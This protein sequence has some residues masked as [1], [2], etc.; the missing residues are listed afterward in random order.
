L[1][2]WWPLEQVLL[3]VLGSV[4]GALGSIAG[5]VAVHRRELTRQYRLRLYGDLLPAIRS[6]GLKAVGE[7]EE[8]PNPPPPPLSGLLEATYQ[9]QHDA[10]ITGR[11]EHELAAKVRSRAV[12]AE[13]L[14]QTIGTNATW[15]PS[16]YIDALM[17]IVGATYPLEAY[18]RNKIK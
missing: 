13:R 7:L 15:D 2:Y 12:D 1:A 17:E 16:R 11:R 3:V 6:E 5:S 14:L 18:L 10:A 4:L 9:L 8:N